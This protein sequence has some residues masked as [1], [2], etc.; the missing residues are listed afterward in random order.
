MKIPTYLVFFFSALLM[1]VLSPASSFAAVFN[2]STTAGVNT[3]LASAVAGDEIIVADGIYSGRFNI[4]SNSGTATSPITLRAQNRHGAVFV[5]PNMDAAG[6]VNDGFYIDKSYWIIDGFEFKFHSSAIVTPSYS[7]VTN[8]EI[9]HNLIH[10]FFRDGIR[11]EQASNNKIHHNVIAFSEQPSSANQYGGI[12]VRANSSGNLIQDNIVYSMTNDKYILQGGA[13]DGIGFDANNDNN[14]VQGNLIMDCGYTNIKIFTS[15]NSPATVESANN[16]VRDNIVAFSLSG[17]AGASHAHSNYNTFTN[18]LFYNVFF[19]SFTA[20]GNFIGQNV[21]THNT[22]VVTQFSLGGALLDD[23]FGRSSTNSTVKDNLFYSPIANSGSHYLFHA[24]SWASSILESDYNLF[25][26][27]G[28]DSGTN[29]TWNRNVVYGPNDIHSAQPIFVNEAIGDFTLAAGSPGKGSASDGTDRGAIFNSHLKKQWMQSIIALPTQELLTSGGISLAFTSSPTHQYQVYSYLPETGY[30]TGT[31]T[32]V[33]EGKNVAVDMTS[34][35]TTGVGS[36]S[37]WVGAAP[38]RWIYLGT[39]PNNGTL[40][41]TWTQANASSKFLIRELP[42]VQE[43]YAWMANADSQP[44][45]TASFFASPNAISSG[46]SS[47]LTWSSA[48]A[49]SCTASGGW[50]GSKALSGSQSV[51]PMQTTTY[52][53]SCI[54][55]GGETSQSTTVNVSGA[56]PTAEAPSGSRTI[57]GN[58][59]DW[60]GVASY[61]IA[62]L[63]P[64]AA[65]PSLADLTATFKAAWDNTYL[66]ILTEV[67]DNEYD[68]SGGAQI[69]HHDGIE[70]MIDGLHNRSTSFGS[71]DHQIFI[72]ADGLSQATG[73]TPGDGKISV[74]ATR[75]TNGY[76]LETAIRWDFI[77]GNPPQ[78]NQLYGFTIDVNDRDNETR[79]SQVF[80]KYAGNHYADTSQYGDLKLWGPIVSTLLPA[81]TNVSVK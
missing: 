49:T 74:S 52:T 54:G 41:I 42:T 75:T 7:N 61:P 81:P 35:T 9:R 26:R 24:Y 47:T 60:A 77:A 69:Y 62:Q 6:Y 23:A 20:K 19:A 16:V 2:V 38:R 12:M 27:P 43:A 32:F 64:T 22:S 13:G 55:S 18:N 33:I 56:I 37:V 53:L 28:P 76:L 17:G 8:L 14:L 34:A 57:D 11:L 45:S 5:G 10:D 66:Y 63:N 21:F 30:Y 50:S 67:I 36:S 40:N 58:S 68:V 39:H 59:A 79:E 31:E 72:R 3:A 80:W 15:N 46:E 1:L 71:D 29:T 44:P 70:I 48:N 51:T 73:H 4:T 25:W 65:P 78:A